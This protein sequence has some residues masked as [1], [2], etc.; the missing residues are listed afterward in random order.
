MKKGF[1]IFGIIVVLFL[2]T[3]V[4]A[5]TMS[6]S[7]EMG[8]LVK[9]VLKSKGIDEGSVGDIREVDFNNLPSGININNIDETNLALYEVQIGSEDKPVYILTASESKFKKVIAK[10]SKKMF[11]NFGHSGEITESGYLESATGV[12]GNLDKGY[13]MMREGSVSG[14]STNLEVLEGGGRVEV[15]IYKNGEEVGFRNSF[16]VVDSGIYDDY[17]VMSEGI[18]NFEPGD[19]ISVYVNLEKDIKI[20]DVITL[21]EVVTD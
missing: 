15:F 17:D 4:V 12:L 14:I 11:L 10:F 3:S 7:E 13:V 20:N 16:D 1:V 6:V 8:V 19:L 5:E 2:A 9:D 21:L 18:L